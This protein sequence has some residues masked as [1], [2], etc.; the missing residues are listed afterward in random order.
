MR[1]I[2]LLLVLLLQISLQAQGDVWQTWTARRHTTAVISADQRLFAVADG[3]LYSLKRDDPT[4]VVLYDRASGLGDVGIERIAWSAGARQL[5]IYYASGMIDLLGRD[6]VAHISALKEASHIARRES[7]GL[8]T[9]G[10]R[11]WLSGA[12]GILQIDIERGVIEATYMP[13]QP[14]L[15][16]A[17][18]PANDA[19]VVA[20]DA[21]LLQGRLADNLQD[22]SRWRDINLTSPTKDA[23]WAELGYAGEVLYALDSEGDLYA[24]R[25][26]RATR[27][28]QT[29]RIKHLQQSESTLV[30][31]TDSKVYWL[32][33]DASLSL[34]ASLD[35]PIAGVSP[36]VGGQELWLAR[37]AE[38]IDRLRLTNGVWERSP[39]DIKINSPISNVFYTIRSQGGR[40]YSVVGGRGIDRFG[41]WGAVQIFDGKR[42]STIDEQQMSRLSGVPFKDPVDIIPHRDGDPEHYYVATWGEGLYEMKGER[43]VERYDV[44]N[45]ALSSAVDGASGFTRVGSLAYDAKGNLWMA[46]GGADDGGQGNIVRLAPDGSW[47]GY[48]YIPIQGTNSFHSQIALANGTKWLLDHHNANRSSGFF[49]YQDKGTP[50][51]DDDAYGHYTSVQEFS[52]RSVNFSRI[53]AMAL[54]K[55]GALWLGGSMGFFSVANPQRV[56]QAGQAP[57]VSRPVAG[58]APSL[59]YV[60]DNI[61]VTAIAVDA[62]NRKWMGTEREG[63]Y[64]LSANGLEILR[65]YKSE[66]SPLLDNR[67]LSLAI[68]EQTGRLYIG[69]SYGLNVLDTGTSLGA[70]EGMPSAIA[71]PNPLRPEHPNVITLQGLP[72]GATIHIT[73]ASGRLVHQAESVDQ[74]YRWEVYT[75]SGS[76]LPSGVYSIR[77]QSSLSQEMQML[78]VTII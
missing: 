19:L 31:Y 72:A 52:G 66:D 78:R 2:A 49:I 34:I 57:V 18:S 76:R 50:S 44:H 62:M 41:T 39:M 13:N 56:P 10:S 55:S 73:D 59:Y 6:G 30:C 38:G 22:P 75:S 46:L 26:G 5:V 23:H 8:L 51:I 7:S 47:Q 54:D 77:I 9:Q 69:T 64:L 16:L 53:S 15:S 21:G 70:R 42:W 36:M 4:D 28:P 68:D 1:Q 11:A 43:L 3:S 35:A 12:F 40:L 25:D 67:I 17:L 58:T 20:T 63:L 74:T 33:E 65:H 29:E 45:S 32:R 14:I 48:D 60:L 61:P 24:L 37:G 27:V 71:Y